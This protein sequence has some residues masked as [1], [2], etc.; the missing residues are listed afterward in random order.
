[1]HGKSKHPAGR[2]AHARVERERDLDHTNPAGAQNKVDRIDSERLDPSI[3]LAD[4]L[5]AD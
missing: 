3:G 5:V 2:P 4:R 1:M